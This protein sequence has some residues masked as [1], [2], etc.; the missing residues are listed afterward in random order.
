MIFYSHVAGEMEK[1]RRYTESRA[2][3]STVNAG[4]IVLIVVGPIARLRGC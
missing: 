2:A 1:S 4:W 3:L